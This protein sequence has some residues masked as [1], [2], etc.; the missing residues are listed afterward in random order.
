MTQLLSTAPS[1][2]EAAKAVTRYYMG[3]ASTLVPTDNKNKW[4]VQRDSDGAILPGVHVVKVKN[5]YRFE[6]ED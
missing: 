1:L 2:I 5:R 3:Q 6:M 4:H